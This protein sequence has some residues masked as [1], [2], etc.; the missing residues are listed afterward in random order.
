[1]ARFVARLPDRR[2]ENWM[3]TD[4]RLF[5]PKAWGLRPSPSADAPLPLGLLAEFLESGGSAGSA[6]PLDDETVPRAGTRLAG[7][8][9]SLDGHV[10][11]DEL[12]PALAARG[13]VFGRHC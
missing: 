6:D 13:V 10:L 3:R 7:R 11:V 5:K 12:D 1:M 8:L 4:L 9:L 2:D